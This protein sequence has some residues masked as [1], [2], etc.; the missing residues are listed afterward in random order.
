[1]RSN[2]LSGLGSRKLA[3]SLHTL[4]SAGLLT[5][6]SACG[7]AARPTANSPTDDAS[8]LGEP[9]PEGE[10]AVLRGAGTISLSSLRGKVVLL[11]FWASW[12]APCQE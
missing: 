5:L 4:L 1:M 8:L 9:A 6:L 11:D 3:F 12:C 7:G 10:F 2:V